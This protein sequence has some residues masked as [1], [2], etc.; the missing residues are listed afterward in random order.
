MTPVGITLSSPVEQP[1]P[2]DLQATTGPG[3]FPWLASDS[4]PQ[5]EFQGCSLVVVDFFSNLSLE[6]WNKS[7]ICILRK[8]YLITT[9][10]IQK[11]ACTVNF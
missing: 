6:S 5:W 4:H 8:I 1:S 10:Q 9:Q 7:C 3:A 2:R 11:I